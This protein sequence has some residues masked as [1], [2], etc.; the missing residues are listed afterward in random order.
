MKKQT[1][2]PT[3]KE[4]REHDKKFEEFRKFKI[5][6][7]KNK[8]MKEKECKHKWI[9]NGMIIKTSYEKGEEVIISIICEKCGKIKIKG[10]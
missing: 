2:N 3:K 10:I 6:E 1:K 5:K 4:L 8:N 9:P 7:L